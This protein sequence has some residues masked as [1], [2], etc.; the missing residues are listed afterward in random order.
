MQCGPMNRILVLLVILLSGC[1]NLNLS[2]ILSQELPLTESTVASGLR[3]A[4]TVGTE[5]ASG[6]LGVADAFAGVATRRIAIPEELQGITDRLR[7]LG[8]DG[9]VDD[10]E[11]R[12]NRAAESAVP[13]AVDIF[14]DAI[15][16][17]TIQDAFAI[18]NGPDDA[19]TM[20]FRDRT[21][22][23]LM[24]AFRPQVNGVMSEVGVFRVYDQLLNR[25][26]ALPIS[27]APD[28]DLVGHIVSRTTA[29]LFSE[30]AAEEAHIRQDPAARTTELLRR[31]FSHQNQ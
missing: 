11:L 10:F 6:R 24:S 22:E 31:V 17:M 28:V 13:L 26:N 4:L 7:Q 20:Y 15:R 19:A 8:L 16:Q 9:Q 29:A 2:D 1:A 27:N 18:L 3:E 21:T 14:A 5:R 23:A 25:Y 30:L 12:M